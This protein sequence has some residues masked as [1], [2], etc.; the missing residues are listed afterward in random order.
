MG[1]GH[2][3]QGCCRRQ[4]GRGPRPRRPTT[5]A[6]L[7]EG[8]GPQQLWPERPQR[9]L[10]PHPRCTRH[11]KSPACQPAARWRTRLCPPVGPPHPPHH[12]HHH[13]LACSA[14]CSRGPE[15]V[16]LVLEPRP[17]RVGAQWGAQGHPPLGAPHP[18]AP[19]CC[20]AASA[21]ASAPRQPLT[22]VARL[23][24]APA[25]AW[26]SCRCTLRTGEGV[27]R[28]RPPLPCPPPPPPCRC[29]WAV[30]HGRCGPG[31]PLPLPRPRPRL[32]IG[33]HPLQHKHRN[34]RM[35]RPCNRQKPP[36]TL[37]VQYHPT[38]QRSH[39]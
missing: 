3:E 35:I 12:H 36:K 9:Q 38:R 19:R 30:A 15:G 18:R 24:A 31:Q 17:R 6:C 13:S 22:A 7:G 11:P 33:Y 5:P 16:G 1:H 2:P 20:G 25:A 21:S 32:L 26:R 37:M 4:A 14:P 39:L 29:A 23:T 34:P 28:P 10:Q 8:R 27:A